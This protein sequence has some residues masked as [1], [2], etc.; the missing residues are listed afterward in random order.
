MHSAEPDRPLEEGHS[1]HFA[2]EK[3]LRF[4]KGR[5][6]IFLQ[7]RCSFY[8][9]APRAVGLAFAF[10]VWSFRGSEIPTR[11]RPVIHPWPQ[12]IRKLEIVTRIEAA[13][14]DTNR[15]IDWCK[16]SCHQKGSNQSREGGGRRRTGGREMESGEL[17][18]H[19]DGRSGGDVF[20][21][22]LDVRASA[23]PKALRVDQGYFHGRSAAGFFFHY[24][25]ADRQRRTNF[26]C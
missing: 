25:G 19:A 10:L 26:F 14:L 5:I 17:S 15:G 3:D 12:P 22:R 4:E 20:D 6:S 18:Q 23:Q 21:E 2:R 1:L 24:I 11:G 7:P 9:A 8:A 16:A 13:A